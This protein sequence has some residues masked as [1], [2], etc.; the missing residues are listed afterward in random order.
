MYPAVRVTEHPS[1]RA[2]V[3]NHDLVTASLRT[4]AFHWTFLSYRYEEH[5]GADVEAADGPGDPDALEASA[6]LLQDQCAVRR[7]PT[8]TALEPQVSAGWAQ[9]HS[10][11]HG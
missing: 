2:L 11:M 7:Q 10:S 6:T 3:K 5:A 8:V 1:K 4:Q 9:L